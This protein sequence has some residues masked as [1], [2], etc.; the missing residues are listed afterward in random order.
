MNLETEKTLLLMGPSR[1]GKTSI[2]NVVFKKMQPNDTL[3]LDSTLKIT[4]STI[5]S[6]IKF[7][8]WDFPTNFDSHSTEIYQNC[9]ALV[10]VIDAQDDFL[11]ALQKLLFTVIQ[12]HKYNPKIAFEVFIHKVDGLSDDHKIG[13]FD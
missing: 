12:A 8:V 6:F 10:F 7:Q 5:N 4:K 3:F 11:D 2:A 9:G 1:S 13:I